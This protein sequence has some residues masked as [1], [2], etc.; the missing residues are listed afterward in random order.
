MPQI[1]LYY[2]FKRLRDFIGYKITQPL[3]YFNLYPNLL[4]IP[5]YY[6]FK[7]LH[8]FIAKKSRNLSRVTKLLYPKWVQI[9]LYYTFKRLRDFIAKKNHATSQELYPNLA[10]IPLYSKKIRANRKL[11]RGGG[12]SRYLIPASDWPAIRYGNM[13]PKLRLI[14]LYSKKNQGYCL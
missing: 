6:T 8:D 12:Q 1:P 13:Y 9:P 2:T 3:K 7:R 10:Q 4:Q 5:L 14:P 11:R